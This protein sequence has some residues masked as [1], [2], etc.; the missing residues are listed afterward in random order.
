MSTL[1][2][3]TKTRDLP[4]FKMIVHETL[5]HPSPTIIAQIQHEMVVYMDHVRIALIII[6]LNLLVIMVLI[7][8]IHSMA[9]KR[10]AKVL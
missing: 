8:K 5:I 9:K 10:E 3:P 1:A 4:L 7:L 6:I 2:M